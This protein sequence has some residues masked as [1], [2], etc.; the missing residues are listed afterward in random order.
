MF[1]WLLTLTAFFV[2]VA[3]VMASGRILLRRSPG[4]NGDLPGDPFRPRRVFGPLNAIL[5]ALLPISQ[6]RRA[7]LQRELKQ[8]GYYQPFAAANYLAVRNAMLYLWVL[9]TAFALLALYDAEQDPTVPILIVGAVVTV[10][11]FALPR[12]A[13]QTMAGR[14]VRHIQ[15][16]LP[17]GLDM[18]N[19]CVAGGLSLQNAFR[20]VSGQ[21]Y[22]AHPALGLEFDI[23]RR[24]SE[25]Y[26]MERAMELFAERLD[27]PD[28]KA[29]SAVVTQAERLGANVSTALQEYAD[30]MRLAHRQRAEEQGNKRSVQMLFPVALCLA[31]PVYILLLA[32]GIL[33]LYDFVQRENRPGGLLSQEGADIPPASLNP[34]PAEDTQSP[35]TG[36]L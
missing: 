32:P 24:H 29:M 25:T 15:T 19:M 14:R 2:L 13:L 31:P 30:S 26:T 6:R 34:E 12:L 23:I 35:P 9:A 1:D 11:F 21:I 18:L 5:A 4:E 3:L 20:R 7:S 10:S 27:L 28:I 16:A 17:D 33:E 8:G 22:P 36:G